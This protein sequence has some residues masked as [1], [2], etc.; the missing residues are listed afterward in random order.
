MNNEEKIIEQITTAINALYEIEDIKVKIDPD[1]MLGGTI[2]I[3]LKHTRESINE[4]H[5][6]L[7]FLNKKLVWDMN[8][9][10]FISVPI[11]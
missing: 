8:T 7:A 4:L 9:N 10:K 11:D 1:S 2:K 5:K 3:T 6:A